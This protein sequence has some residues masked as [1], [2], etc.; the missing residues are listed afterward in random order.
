MVNKNIIISGLIN[1]YNKAIKH[2]SNLK[3]VITLLYLSK[4]SSNN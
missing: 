2:K 4:R 1:E 3:Y